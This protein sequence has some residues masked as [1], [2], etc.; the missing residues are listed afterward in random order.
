[1]FQLLT[2][3][4]EYLV[5]RLRLDNLGCDQFEKFVGD[6]SKN[7]YSD[8]L[9]ALF[10]AFMECEDALAIT[11]VSLLTARL[12]AESLSIAMNESK[13]IN[14]RKTREN[15]ICFDT[16]DV[17]ADESAMRALILHLHTDYP[18]DPGALCPLLL[19]C[20]FLSEGEAFFMGSN[21]PHAYIS[22]ET[23]IIYCPAKLVLYYI[24][25]SCRVCLCCSCL[26]L[27][28]AAHFY[29]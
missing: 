25:F 23:S 22:G 18:N 6:G 8:V 1:M 19:N 24:C 13:S 12:T 11:Q 4:I 10:T 20:L 29:E 7:C 9:R 16:L 27:F 14:K 21:E 2:A 3:I 17:V 26:S 5:T 15:S 28:V